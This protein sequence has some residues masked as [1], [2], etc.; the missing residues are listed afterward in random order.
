MCYNS[1]I[2]CMKVGNIRMRRLLS[3]A[4]ALLMLLAP[5]AQ[6]ALCVRMDDGA[7]LLDRDGGEIVS[8]GTHADIVALG[9]DLYAACGG[10][11]LY[12]LMDETGALRTDFL[13]DQLRNAEG[14]LLAQRDGLWGMLRADGTPLSGFVYSWMQPNGVGG[15]WAIAGD[16]SDTESDAL[17]RVTA[18]GAALETGLRVH[19]VG[20]GTEGMLS[21]QLPG[22][23]RYGYC[24]AT[25]ALA[26]PAQFDYAGD[27]TCGL[28]AVVQNGHYGS[29]DTS[30]AWVLEPNY[31]F[32]QISPAGFILA[33]VE[34]EGVYVFDAS[35][36][37][38]ARYE[39]SDV[40]AALAGEGYVV[41][42]PD[43]LQLYDASGAL[44]L[45]TSPD[46]SVTEGIGGQ[47]IVSDGA[48]GEECVRLLGS[49]QA[50]QN[51]Y[52]LGTVGEDA[53]YACMTVNVGR[54][55]ND[56]LGEIQ[57]STDM[58]SARYG[59]VG[60]DGEVLLEP[61]YRAL[62]FLEDDRLLARSDEAWLVVDSG[63]RVYWQWDAPMQ[64]EATSF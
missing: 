62:Y 5:C 55:M 46:A 63:G 4:L 50:Y 37:E 13:Y 53:L 47:W 2:D 31:D 23:R 45:E 29:V 35:G 15:A 44:M 3:V 14:L 25:G 17:Y 11:G 28:A 8:P 20:G 34:L 54:Y 38:R 12:A 42:N 1:H 10:D 48:W 16:R 33:A 49:E 7:A 24:D 36:A 59:V 27:F 32:L 43:A 18:G 19:A 30:G 61:V 39:G 51:L 57:L 40:Y 60:S 64:T 9:G 6:A 21:V 22:A 58:D 56:R 52:P 41:S 26:I